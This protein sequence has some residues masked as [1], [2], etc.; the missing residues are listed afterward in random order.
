MPFKYMK[1]TSIKLL[2][3]KS[4]FSL[5]NIYRSIIFENVNIS[6]AF[7]EAFVKFGFN[8]VKRM[9]FWHLIKMFIQRIETG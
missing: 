9:A 2:S 1:L 3:V 7:V 5:I 4:I 6:Y 8:T